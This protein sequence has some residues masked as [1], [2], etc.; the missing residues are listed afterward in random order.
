MSNSSTTGFET[1]AELRNDRTDA[2]EVADT[3]LEALAERVSVEI[4]ENADDDPSDDGLDADDAEAYKVTESPETTYVWA[5]CRGCGRAVH[6]LSS[7]EKL[8]H[9]PDCPVA[10]DRRVGQ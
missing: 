9:A 6:G 3:D 7:V 10:P 8:P 5:E 4:P 1:A 2:A